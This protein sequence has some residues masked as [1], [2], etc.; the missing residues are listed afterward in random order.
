MDKRLAT[1][2]DYDVVM[3]FYNDIIDHQEFDEYGANWTKD[4]YPSSNDILSHIKNEELFIG[5]Y[6]EDIISCGVV[7]FNEDPMYHGANWSKN[8]SDDKI[9][10][11][12]LFAINPKFRGKG[13]SK[14]M[15]EYL[16]DVCSKRVEAIHLDVVM[17]NIPAEKLYLSV[18][19]KFVCEFEVY[20]ED[21]GDMVVRLFEYNF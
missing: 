16:I 8:L 9:G 5:Y 1:L 7:T 12:H 6:G 15:L 18:G 14:E 11:L 21:T 3:K 19:F 17:G 13:Y 20:Y 4:I 10:V 2:S